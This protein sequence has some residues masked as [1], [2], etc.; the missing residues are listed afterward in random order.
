MLQQ[1]ALFVQLSQELSKCD[2]ARAK[3]VAQL[4]QSTCKETEESVAKWNL[5]SILDGSFTK[6]LV[7]DPS[8][9]IGST[10]DFELS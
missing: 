6:Q 3:L 7:I 2:F 8:D 9:I 5:A 4:R 10:E 1:K